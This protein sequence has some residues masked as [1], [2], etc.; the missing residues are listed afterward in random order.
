MPFGLVL[1]AV[2]ASSIEQCFV[3]SRDCVRRTYPLYS[4]LGSYNMDAPAAGE[5]L[6]LQSL[7]NVIRSIHVLTLRACQCDCLLVPYADCLAAIG[8]YT[9]QR[10]HVLSCGF[11]SRFAVSENGIKQE[12]TFTPRASTRQSPHAL[13]IRAW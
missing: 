5:L 12:H 10:V 11:G 6:G 4:G 1:T 9:V 7:A 8:I 3:F 13:T 2:H